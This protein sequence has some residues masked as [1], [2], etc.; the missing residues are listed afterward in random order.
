MKL[1]LLV[2]RGGVD[3]IQNRGDVIEVE[4]DE[5]MR[6]IESGAAELYRDE[7]GPELAV[8]KGKKEKAVK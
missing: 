8:A 1:K 7:D 4:N 6:L 5:A 2:S 3:F